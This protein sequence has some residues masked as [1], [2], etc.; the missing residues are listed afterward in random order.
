MRIRT[1]PLNVVNVRVHLSARE[2]VQGVVGNVS[3]NE[4]RLRGRMVLEQDKG[5]KGFY[6]LAMGVLSM[7]IN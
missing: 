5:T 6:P 7:F 3:L 4:R 2:T 1:H